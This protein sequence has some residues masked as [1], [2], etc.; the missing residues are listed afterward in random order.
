MAV[1]ADVTWST[2]LRQP[3]LSGVARRRRPRIHRWREPAREG[4]PVLGD[5]DWIVGKFVGLEF[6]KGRLLLFNINGGRE[7]DTTANRSQSVV[8]LHVARRL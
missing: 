6:R 3:T 7:R 2:L 5:A 1:D 8:Q 4:Q